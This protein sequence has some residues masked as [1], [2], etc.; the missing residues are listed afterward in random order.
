MEIFDNVHNIVLNDVLVNKLKGPVS[1]PC[2]TINFVLRNVDSYSVGV[3]LYD[4]RVMHNLANEI[5]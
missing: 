4:P 3:Q 5:Y 2:L 1:F